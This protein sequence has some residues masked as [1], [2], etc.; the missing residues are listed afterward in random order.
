MQAYKVTHYRTLTTTYEVHAE[1]E[2]QALELWHAEPA[3]FLVLDEATD[4]D[5]VEVLS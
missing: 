5:D 1:S 3:A 4:N 2:E